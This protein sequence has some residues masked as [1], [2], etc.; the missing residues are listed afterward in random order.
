MPKTIR[1]PS[2]AT[3]GSVAAELAGADDS[4]AGG[5]DAAGAQ[6]ASANQTDAAAIVL[7]PDPPL[8]FV[9][10]GLRRV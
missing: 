6:A 5:V 3:A 7:S 10:S 8:V 1:P 4:A 9:A 2:A